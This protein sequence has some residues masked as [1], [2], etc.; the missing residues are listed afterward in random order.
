MAPGWIRLTLDPDLSSVTYARAVIRRNAAARGVVGSCARDAELVVSELVTNAITHGTPPIG[1]HIGIDSSI[2]VEVTDTGAGVPR[3][4]DPGED[5]GWGLFLVEAVSTHW[6]C[7]H[8]G[9]H[10]SVWAELGPVEV[11]AAS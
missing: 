7:E 6:G 4:R 3:R 9:D 8:L 2:R 11:A 10:K 1:L 5:G